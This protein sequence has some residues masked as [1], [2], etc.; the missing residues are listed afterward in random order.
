[1]SNDI[2]II[3]LSIN[4]P[5]TEIELPNVMEFLQR[6]NIII[7]GQSVL[8]YHMIPLSNRPFIYI[9]VF[10]YKRS[11]FT[12][13]ISKLVHE[14]VNALKQFLS[15]YA[16]DK[17]RSTIL[18]Y[19]RSLLTMRNRTGS[20]DK[21]Q[22]LFKIENKEYKISEYVDVRKDMD[23]KYPTMKRYRLTDG[24]YI[25]VYYDPYLIDEYAII[26]N[27]S[28]PFSE[29]NYQYNTLHLYEHL[30]T[31]AWKGHDRGHEVYVNGLTVVNGISNVFAILDSTDALMTYLQ[32][33]ISFTLAARDRNF[34]IK[35]KEMVQTETLR[36]LSETRMSRSFSVPSRSD[37]VAYDCNYNTDIFCKW[38]NDPFDILLISNTPIKIDVNALNAKILSAKRSNVKIP[39]P[40]VPFIP[41]EAIMDKKEVRI[42][43]ESS[44]NIIDDI[45]RHNFNGVE[46]RLY[47]VDN[48]MLF[49]VHYDIEFNYNLHGL[50]YLHRFAKDK[51][52]Y[53][54]KIIDY[55]TFPWDFKR[56]L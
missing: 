3:R 13:D 42:I 14:R 53:D 15:T 52:A 33:F 7:A 18:W 6:L 1:M 38:S 4:L 47:G 46:G 48:Y 40:E 27:L 10:P 39:I 11:D 25:S 19:F 34:W 30:M 24:S 26:C 17:E 54:K 44:E 35:N 32:N 31:Y 51:S 16:F 21:S 55:I 8:N 9:P 5:I 12:D 50:L 20:R 28:K 22:P 43:K 41:I 2:P 45:F 37:P 36:T 29:M 49:P 23:I 56:S